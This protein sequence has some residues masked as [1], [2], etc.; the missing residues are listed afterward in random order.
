M[1][2]VTQQQLV[3]L[4]AARQAVFRQL[5]SGATLVTI[6]GEP[7]GQGWSQTSTD[8]R[9]LV[10][11]GYP[12]ARPDCFW[13]DQSL[14]LANGAMPHASNVQQIPEAAET[15]LWFSWHVA[16]WD[17]NRDSLVTYLYVIRTRLKEAR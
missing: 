10:P 12:M 9:F 13:A 4:T 11:V 6:T 15:A 8:I 1:T 16:H 14:R 5:P 7:L 2:T 3:E 17:P